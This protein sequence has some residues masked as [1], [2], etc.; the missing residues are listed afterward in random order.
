M[1]RD[2]RSIKRSNWGITK[3]VVLKWSKD[4]DCSS[5]DT[6]FTDG[7]TNSIFKSSLF[8]V[9]VILMGQETQRWETLVPFFWYFTAVI[10]QHGEV[11]MWR[12]DGKVG[13]LLQSWLLRFE[14]MLSVIHGK[15]FPTDLPLRAYLL[16]H[17]HALQYWFTSWLPWYPCYWRGIKRETRHKKARDKASLGHII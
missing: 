5:R 3:R 15:G 17:K 2:L 9:L 16:F 8:C 12:L 11:C 13:S 7:Y 1:R 10:L 4:L 6:A 14:L